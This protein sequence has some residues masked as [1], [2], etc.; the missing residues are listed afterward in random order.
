MG[1][2]KVNKYSVVGGKSL[3]TINCVF[4][5]NVSGPIIRYYFKTSIVM[6]EFQRIV[7]FS[8][9]PPIENVKKCNKKEIKNRF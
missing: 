6:K 1:L 9:K 7:C 3:Q 5:I 4:N 8:K 2:Q